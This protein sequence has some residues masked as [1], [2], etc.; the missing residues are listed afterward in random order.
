MWDQREYLGVRTGRVQAS[1][2]ASEALSV[3]WIREN[4][5]E[6]LNTQLPLMGSRRGCYVCIMR[7]NVAL[8]IGVGS[9]GATKASSKNAFHHAPLATCGPATEH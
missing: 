9:A 4:S 5:I 1:T 6:K 2:S 3:R 8:M 7:V